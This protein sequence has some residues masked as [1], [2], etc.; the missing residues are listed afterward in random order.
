MSSP[1]VSRLTSTSRRGIPKV[2]TEEQEARPSAA[3]LNHSAASPRRPGNEGITSSASPSSSS[4]PSIAMQNQGTKGVKEDPSNLT[5]WDAW[6]YYAFKLNEAFGNWNNRQVL[7]TIKANPAVLRTYHD[8]FLFGEVPLSVKLRA[9][10][11]GGI[12]GAVWNVLE[13]VLALLSG[14]LYVYSTYEPDLFSNWAFRIQNGISFAFLAD[15][16]LRVVS[17]P[18]KL[19]FIF[20]FW[21]AMDLLSV[22]PIILVFRKHIHGSH[23]LE[24]LTFIRFGRIF[25]F[26][27][28]WGFFRSSVTQQIAVLSVITMGAIFLDAGILQWVEYNFASPSTKAS[29]PVQGCMTFWESWYFLIVTVSTV[30]YGDITPKTMIGQLIAII[31]IIAALT[32]L[33]IQ[34]SRITSLAYRRPYGGSFSSTKFHASRFLIISGSITFTAIQ[35]SLAEFYNATHSEDLDSYPLRVVVLAPFAPSFELKQLLAL[36]N[37]YVEFI[38]GSPVRQADLERVNADHAAAFFLLA[39]QES[40]NHQVEDAAQ[41][42]RALA[43]HRF[44]INSSRSRRKVRIIIEVLDPETQRSSVW[45]QADRACIEVICAVTIH[46]KMMARS[47]A[48][49]GLYTLI[50]NLFTSELQIKYLN[51]KHFL[52]ECFHSFDNEVYP[53]V[54]PK[55]FHGLPFEEVAEF[56]FVTFN[57]VLLGLDTPVGYNPNTE[58]DRKVLLYPKGQLISSDD[59][60]IVIASD[61]HTAYAISTYCSKEDEESMCHK[62]WVIATSTPTIRRHTQGTELLDPSSGKWRRSISTVS[63]AHDQVGFENATFGEKRPGSHINHPDG[64][65]KLEYQLRTAIQDVYSQQRYPDWGKNQ[66]ATAEIGI[67]QGRDVENPEFESESV[68]NIKAGTGEP[69]TDSR[70]RFPKG[71]T[72]EK[73]A[74]E[75]L[76]WPPVSHLDRPHPALLEE[77]K[78]VIMKDLKERTISMVAFNVPHILVCCQTGWPAHFFYFLVELRKPGFPNPP[79]VML[80][81]REVNAKEWGMVGAFKDVYFLKGSP[82]YELDLLRAGVLQAEKIVILSD[83]GIPVDLGGG[84]GEKKYLRRAPAAYTSDV[85]NIIVS[86]N[87]QRLYGYN[88]LDNIIVEM[89]HPEAFFY[90]R[91]QYEISSAHFPRD[92]LRRNR[93]G[94]VHF[95]PPYMEGKAISAAMLGFLMRSSF[96]NRNTQT[97]VEQMI[98][99]GYVKTADGL[100]KERQ[101]IFDQICLPEQ[102]GNRPYSDLFLSLLREKGILAIGLYRV[103]GTLGAP[104]AY[105]LTN[106]E[107]DCIVNPDD[108]VYVL[109]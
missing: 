37:G 86:A 50:T 75:L 83:Q 70:H 90:L 60:G 82:Q 53:V 27:T 26:R 63:R 19:Y 17:E 30:G 18:V 25:S 22:F 51:R 93:D 76:A 44:C 97:I 23:L 34:I 8:S 84:T 91:P 101:R 11:R 20:S 55:A 78:D 105:V 24:L 94:L 10:M 4:N 71:K 85:K 41:I 29:C 28:K 100:I 2:D 21:G 96:Y 49:H 35:S 61:L 68:E 3:S 79:V 102:Y 39:D 69:A 9:T 12:L 74:E 77:K 62:L 6:H 16:V 15:Y 104:T 88:P 80:Y 43:V 108:R 81:P 31:T 58:A 99:G 89:K 103:R 32:I 46:Y 92:G 13:F 59:V 47:C 109:H 64:N 7:K 52:T 36:Y 40:E 38:E 107:P 5:T 48:V 67:L 87:V 56:I 42:V 1:H 54:L 98:E 72:L 45:D 65:L 66:A 14:V 95:L 73:A 57:S 106:P 33:P